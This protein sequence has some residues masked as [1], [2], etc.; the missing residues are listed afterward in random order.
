MKV[1]ITGAAGFIGYHV[2]AKLLDSGIAVVGVDNLSPYYDVA[3][4]KARVARL[5]GKA[6]FTFRV[7]DITDHAA[8][9]GLTADHGDATHV[10]HLGQ[11]VRQSFPVPISV[12]L[13]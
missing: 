2:A 13:P 1:I 3:L 9:V 11:R 6:G 5:E 4:K 8:M 12:L 7:F 10:L